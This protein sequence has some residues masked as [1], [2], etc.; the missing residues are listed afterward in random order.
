MDN[1]KTIEDGKEYLLNLPL[2]ILK[3]E[4]PEAYQKAYQKAYHKAVTQ[5]ISRHKKEFEELKQK[6]KEDLE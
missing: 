5:L 2:T 4:E 3:R 1:I 6:L